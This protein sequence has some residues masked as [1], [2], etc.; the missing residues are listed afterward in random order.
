MF[1]DGQFSTEA[2]PSLAAPL[3]IN[4]EDLDAFVFRGMVKDSTKVHLYE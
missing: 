2:L 3:L 1:S 4:N